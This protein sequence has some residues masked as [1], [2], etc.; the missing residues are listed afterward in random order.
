MVSDFAADQRVQD[1]DGKGAMKS[2]AWDRV[3]GLSMGLIFLIIGVVC[4]GYAA[5]GWTY[6]VAGLGGLIFASGGFKVIRMVINQ[7]DEQIGRC[8]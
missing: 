7:M 1:M 6:A 2:I 5:R 8:R 4:L 3:V